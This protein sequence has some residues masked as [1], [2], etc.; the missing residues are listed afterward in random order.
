MD[1]VRRTNT[2]WDVLQE[3]QIDDCR[4]LMVIGGNY[5]GLDRFHQ[6][7]HFAQLPTSRIHVV[8]GE[9]DKDP[10]NVQASANCQKFG[11]LCQR[12]LTKKKNQHRAEAKAKLDNAC[13]LKGIWETDPKE[14]EFNENMNNVRKKLDLHMVSAMPCKLRKTSRNASLR[15]ANDPQE[16]TLAMNTCKERLLAKTTTQ[17]K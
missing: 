4:T 12:N 9:V 13:R 1:V 7:H 10:S 15:A 3:G 2:T 17:R 11:R 14:M 5:Q 6:V 8:W 16:R